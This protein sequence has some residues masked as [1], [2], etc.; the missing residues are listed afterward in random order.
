MALATVLDS[1]SLILKKH[2][3]E[4]E[5]RHKCPCVPPTPTCIHKN[6][7]RPKRGIE[8]A[9][10]CLG[11]EPAD[12]GVGSHDSTVGIHLRPAQPAW[13]LELRV[14]GGIGFSGSV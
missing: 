4:G 2:T 11:G 10:P 3:V 1:L 9:F 13:L 7:M 8:W 14:A 5:K 6:K 12:L